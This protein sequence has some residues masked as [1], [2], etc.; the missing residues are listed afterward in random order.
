MEGQVVEFFGKVFHMA[1]SPYDWGNNISIY[2]IW[3]SKADDL[4]YKYRREQDHD[5]S[6]CIC[7]DVRLNTL[8]VDNL[9]STS[10]YPQDYEI[11]IKGKDRSGEDAQNMASSLVGQKAPEW[12]LQN[13]DDRPVALSD[14][15]SKVLLVNFTGIGCG[16]CQAAVPFLKELKGKFSEEDFDIAAIESWQATVRAVKHYS[17]IK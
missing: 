13:A 14:F 17:D 16:A 6:V 12:V 9:L 15:K 5:V 2:E 11:R 10:F 7:S 3:I 1:D 4:P 8:L